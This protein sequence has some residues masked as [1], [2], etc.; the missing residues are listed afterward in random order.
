VSGNIGE[1]AQRRLES[2]PYS[3]LRA[4]TCD[5]RGG[6]LT[7]RGSVPSHY[8]KQMALATVSTITGVGF[9]NNDIEVLGVPPRGPTGAVQP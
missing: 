7:L 9:V 8:H 6:I 2:S 3:A 5:Y 1:L 4:V